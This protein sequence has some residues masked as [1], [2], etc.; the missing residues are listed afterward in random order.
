M[1]RTTKEEFMERLC[2][3][4]AHRRNAM[5]K[6]LKVA[7]SGFPDAQALVYFENQQMDASKFGEGKT[8][9]VGPSNT[10]TSVQF[11]E[12]KWLNDLPSQRMHPVAYVEAKDFA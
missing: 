2:G 1:I 8:L 6:A 4:D 10:F 12:G 7:L 3:P 5:E 11:C 9:V